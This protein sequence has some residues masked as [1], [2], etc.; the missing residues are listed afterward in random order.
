MLVLHVP[1]PDNGAGLEM[2]DQSARGVPPEGVPG[3][4]R[5]H[6][7]VHKICA[8]WWRFRQHIK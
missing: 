5:Q 1:L 7:L 8:F 3:F 2:T 4:F 6:F